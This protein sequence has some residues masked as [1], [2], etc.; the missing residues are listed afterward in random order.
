MTTIAPPLSAGLMTISLRCHQDMSFLQPSSKQRPKDGYLEVEEGAQR[1]HV[2]MEELA[3][4]TSRQLYML[5][6]QVRELQN[7]CIRLGP[8]KI[9]HTKKS[10][11][12]CQTCGSSP[13]ELYGRSSP[14]LLTYPHTDL[15]GGLPATY[16][17]LALLIRQMTLLSN[18]M[19]SEQSSVQADLLK[20]L[21]KV[22]DLNKAW[23]KD[24]PEKEVAKPVVTKIKEPPRGP[25]TR[26]DPPQRGRP[27]QRRDVGK[28][29]KPMK[30]IIKPSTAGS[31]KV[32]KPR[33]VVME[34]DTR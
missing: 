29:N 21:D 15:S 3:T 20:M 9:K 13:V 30:G 32:E 19:A 2:R 8:E 18:Q 27:V 31:R 1:K 33:K 5:R 23:C 26:Q 22:D 28:E 4:R 24:L 11:R 10:R 34:G 6:Q 16:H 25:F 17:E 12:F 7:E 14:S